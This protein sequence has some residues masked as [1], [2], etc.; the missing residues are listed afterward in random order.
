[1]RGHVSSYIVV[2]IFHCFTITVFTYALMQS[3]CVDVI[4]LR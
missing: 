3:R 4:T 1:M 2:S